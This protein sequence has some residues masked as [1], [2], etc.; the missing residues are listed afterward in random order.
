MDTMN[1][2][3]ALSTMITAPVVTAELLRTPRTLAGDRE[4]ARFQI[5]TFS[6]DITPPLGSPLCGGWITPEQLVDDPLRALG[7]VLL[8]GEKPIVL[9]ALD[10]VETNNSAY[11]IWRE[12]LAEAAGTDASHVAVQCVH[13]HDTPW[14]NLEAHQLAQSADKNLQ[15]MHPDSF[16]T[17]VERS[18][19][20]LKESLTRLKP[21]THIGCGQSRVHQVASAR[22]VLDDEGKVK[23][24]RTS[25]CRDPLGRAFP[26]GLID[27]ELKLVSFWNGAAPVAALHY[28]ATHPMSRYGNG[29]VS[30]DFCGLA[31]D[32]RQTE[33][34]GV[35][36]VYFTGCA[37]DVT[38]GKYNDGSD[39]MRK[40]LTDRMSAAMEAAW[41]D[42]KVDPIVSLN[43][44]VDSVTFGPRPE[45]EFTSAALRATLKDSTAPMFPRLRAA[46]ILSWLNRVDKPVE[47]SRLQSGSINLVHLPGEPFVQYQLLA[48][49]KRPADVVCVAGYG[50]GGMG[51]I[52]LKKSFL[53]G[54]YEPTMAFIND[55]CEEDLTLALS[56]LMAKS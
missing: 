24:T 56:R 40:T 3:T 2:R 28:Y 1:R 5:A 26:E 52:P 30:S 22:R 6:A 45:P 38:A 4:S 23:Y 17:A 41:N 8:G 54:G 48:Q 35:F 19:R 34:P 51:Y 20:A 18:A 14:A 46:I 37:G 55:H 13:P 31:R 49:R 9:C 53:E 15:L 50:D 27:P 7:V 11:D 21:I 33:L 12:S 44:H 16:L 42:T 25:T 10:W 36:Q 47:I 39:G 29:R 32:R 43:W